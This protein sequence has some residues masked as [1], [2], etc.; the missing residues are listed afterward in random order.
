LDI[1]LHPGNRDTGGRHGA[2]QPPWRQIVASGFVLQAEHQSVQRTHAWYE[3]AGR[4]VAHYGCP[5]GAP[6]GGVW[7]AESRTLAA[8]PAG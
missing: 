5:N 2:Q 8:G 7:L 3:H 4:P 1:V 6:P